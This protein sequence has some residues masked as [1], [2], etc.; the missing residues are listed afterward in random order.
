MAK[1]KRQFRSDITTDPTTPMAPTSPIVT[2]EDVARRAYDLYL[3]RGGEHGR[4]R[5]DWL[6]AE[7]ELRARDAGRESYTPPSCEGIRRTIDEV[8]GRLRAEYLEMPGM[9]LTWAQVQRL[10]GIEHTLCQRVLDALV[11]D[12]FLSVTADGHY[13]RATGGA[14]TR[15]RAAIGHAS[16]FASAS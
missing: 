1:T 9:R 6:T 8:I 13:A 5:D 12:T 11:E 15:L 4:D 3:S 7:R 2:N 10:C 14:R 16:R